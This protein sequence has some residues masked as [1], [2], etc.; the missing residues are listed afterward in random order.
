MM[1]NRDKDTIFKS[2]RENKKEMK[3]QD[4]C[5]KRDAE[6][7]EFW[8]PEK[9]REQRKQLEWAASCRLS[10]FGDFCAGNPILLKMHRQM[11][12]TEWERNNPI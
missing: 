11:F 3:R 1:S 10:G 12:Y 7:A 8:T 6:W 2:F 4:Y 5:M 9:Q